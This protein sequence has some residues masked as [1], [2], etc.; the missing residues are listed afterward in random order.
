MLTVGIEKAPRSAR[1]KLLAA[2]LKLKG[3]DL[4]SAMSLTE[5]VLAINPN[6]AEALYLKGLILMG[7]NDTVAAAPILEEAIRIALSKEQ[8]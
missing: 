7:Q 2:R 5:A 3:S 4:E 1:L 6:Q 8:Q